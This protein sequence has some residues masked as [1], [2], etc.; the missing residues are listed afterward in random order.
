MVPH[1]LAHFANTE[2]IRLH[3][4]FSEN[5]GSGRHLRLAGAS[6]LVAQALQSL[7]C[8]HVASKLKRRTR[9]FVTDY[10]ME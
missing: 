6:P 1:L 7:R 10:E 3:P 5:H 4:D 9:S 2:M 8:T